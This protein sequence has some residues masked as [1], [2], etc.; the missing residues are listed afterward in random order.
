[1]EEPGA[2]GLPS[3]F[4]RSLETGVR[5]IEELQR[6][7]DPS[8]AIKARFDKIVKL[9]ERFDAVHILGQMMVM[10]SLIDPNTYAESETPGSAHI[11]ELVAAALISRPGRQGSQELTPAID[12]HTL[13]PL[14]KLTEEAAVFESLRRYSNA[15]GWRSGEEAAK[16]R[17][18]THHLYLRNPGWPWQE[19]E[20]LRGLFGEKRFANRLQGELGFD[21]DEAIA[22][23]NAAALL[24]EEGIYQHMQS[25]SEASSDFGPGHPAYEWADTVFDNKWKAAPAEE[26]ALYIPA[27]WAMNTLGDG[28]LIDDERLGEAAHVDPAH[29]LAYLDVLSTN[30]G[31]EGSWFQL[32]ETIRSRPFI[33]CGDGRYLLTVPDADLWALRPML[34]G[35]LKDGAGYLTHRGKWLERRASEV[36]ARAAMPD[37]MHN[38]LEYEIEAD[39]KRVSGEIDALLRLGA[40]AITV[41]AKS[42]TMRPGA[43][44]GGDALIKHLRETLTKAADQGTRA[45]DALSGDGIF[46]QNGKP[47]E[48]DEKV[49][50]VHPIV[51]TL[52]DLSSVAPVLWELRG[53]KTMPEGTTIPLVVTLHEL[54]LLTD[55]VEWPIQLI[56][57]LRRRSRLNDL[58]NLAA[59]DELDWWMHYL[60]FGLHFEDDETQSRRRFT[61]LTDPLDAWVMYEKGKRDK[62]A[63]KPRMAI[64]KASRSF[65]DLLSE[66]RPP[67]WIQAGC[68]MLDAG[69]DGQKAF[70]SKTKKMRRLARQRKKAQRLTHGY[71]QDADPMMHCAVV[72]PKDRGPELGTVLT[73]Y[74]E[75]RFGEFGEQRTLGIGC[76]VGSERPYDALL[77][78]ESEDRYGGPP[79]KD[80][81]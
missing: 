8:A 48:L 49:I 61:S 23:S 11:V 41:E 35:V 57:F 40:S 37:E 5:V 33:D 74:V 73:D 13:D 17:A 54:E 1:M 67:G 36:L 44:R 71:S 80:R 21:V 70:W 60:F 78:F 65:L 81:G 51:V 14:R 3:N 72:V 32:A 27:V 55:T 69:S 20:T 63:E 16:G 30:F 6:G 79:Q 2:N 39:G 38:S 53:T 19:A 22:C 56:H 12:A 15:G 75:Q 31:T 46:T 25:A 58:G 50:E 47:V 43:K 9:L 4:K 26:A 29:A 18:A 64:P 66:E 59:S 24:T 28:C 45:H 76:A 7:A 77:I 10:E 68:L 62:P 52:D 42:A 34:E